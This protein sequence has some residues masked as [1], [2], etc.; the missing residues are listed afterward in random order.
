MLE[1][2]VI[3]PEIIR[4]RA[5]AKVYALLI[6]L[7]EEKEKQTALPGNFG[8]ETG[9]AVEQTPTDVETCND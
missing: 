2:K 9:K 5:L 3:D 1:S 6:R 7:A 8:E 4:R